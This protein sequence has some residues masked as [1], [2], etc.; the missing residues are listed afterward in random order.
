M[1]REIFYCVNCGARILPEDF[2]S[3]D[4]IALNNQNYCAN[5]KPRVAP[6]I[7]SPGAP[8][9]AEVPVSGDTGTGSSALRRAV[10]APLPTLTSGRGGPP[11]ARHQT[12]TPLRVPALGRSPTSGRPGAGRGAGSKMQSPNTILMIVIGGLVVLILII[13][14]LMSGGGGGGKKLPPSAKDAGKPEV[15]VVKAPTADDLKQLRDDVYRLI[16]EKRKREAT[17]KVEAYKNR[18]PGYDQGALSKLLAEIEA[19]D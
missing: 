13:L 11:V 19:W 12:T 5:C 15:P 14:A 3:G 9:P 7:P 2:E 4:A 18:F 10:R 17:E 6:E 16:Q 1:G 8:E